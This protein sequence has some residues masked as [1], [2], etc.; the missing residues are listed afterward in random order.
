MRYA[1][2]RSLGSDEW[3]KVGRGGSRA[4]AVHKS[5][6]GKRRLRM[7]FGR[8]KTDASR[9]PWEVFVEAGVTCEV[10][11]WVERPAYEARTYWSTSSRLLD[12]RDFGKRGNV[13]VQLLLGVPISV[14]SV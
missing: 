4:C 12:A 7:F 9:L 14:T 3:C 13:L 5:D 10:L 1:W 8:C 2:F 11:L 6:S